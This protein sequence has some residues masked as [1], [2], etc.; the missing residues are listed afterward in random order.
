MRALL[1]N[2]RLILLLTVLALGALTVLAIS[3]NQVPFRE[4]QHFARNGPTN[5]EVPPQDLGAE[6]IHVP[7]CN[8]I[9]VWG[10]LGLML[11]L[12]A[13]LLSPEARKRMLRI[14]FRVAFTFWAIYFLMKR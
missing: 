7:I 1:E 2:K 9:M 6:M 12:I 14:M 10:L 4:G 13:L 5:L 8:Q 11:I 3:L